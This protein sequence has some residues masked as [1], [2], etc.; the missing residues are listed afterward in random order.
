MCDNFVEFLII[1]NQNTN[2]NLIE[3]IH[4][5]YL[6]QEPKLWL[7]KSLLSVLFSFYASYFV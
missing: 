4:Y 7:Q 1:K 5:A 2:E 3:R 6:L